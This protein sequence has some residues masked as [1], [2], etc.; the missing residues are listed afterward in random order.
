M[1]RIPRSA[2]LLGFAGLIPFLWGAVTLLIPQTYDLSL[3]RLGPRFMGQYVLNFYGTIVLAFM[4]GVLWGFATRAEG[5]VA[6]L[7]YALSM[8]PVLWA[9]FTVGGGPDSSLVFLI[10]GYAGLLGLDWLFWRQGL[11][12]PWWMALRVP[13]TLI[14]VLCLFIGLL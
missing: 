12:P 5:R 1:I 8:L 14:V 3:A 10:A 7:G 13:L 2:L 9:F 6:Q 11:A 4:S